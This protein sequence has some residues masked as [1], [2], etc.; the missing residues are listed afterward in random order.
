[1]GLLD[2][3]QDAVGSVFGGGGGGPVQGPPRP[4]PARNPSVTHG[5]GMSGIA[6]TLAEHVSNDT[7]GSYQSTPYNNPRRRH[8]AGKPRNAA[9]YQSSRDNPY[10]TVMGPGALFGGST[11]DPNS[12]MLPGNRNAPVVAEAQEGMLEA[13]MAA[14]SRQGGGA[15]EQFSPIVRAMGGGGGARSS[16]P[17][18]R[19]EQHW[20][21]LAN[22]PY[23]AMGDY[24]V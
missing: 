24:G 14:L 3:L 8:N 11:M 16:A 4:R 6:Q 1:M 12:P 9:V 18:Q 23:G 2:M 13:L 5:F 19:R 21:G 22:R 20:P 10:G 17:I 7:G 15:M